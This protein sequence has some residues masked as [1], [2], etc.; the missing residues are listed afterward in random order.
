MYLRGG[1]YPLTESPFS[2]ISGWKCKKGAVI[3]GTGCVRLPESAKV[4]YI[5]VEA[6]SGKTVIHASTGLYENK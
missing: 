1:E 6:K 3:N 2:L 5:A 4:Y